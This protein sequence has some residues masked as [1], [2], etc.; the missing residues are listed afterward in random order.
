MLC[1]AGNERF[2]LE[3]SAIEVLKSMNFGS[4]TMIFYIKHG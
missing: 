3:A 1:Y 2:S 4:K